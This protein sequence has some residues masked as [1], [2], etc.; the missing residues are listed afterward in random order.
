MRKTLLVGAFAALGACGGDSGS[1]LQGIYS[2]VGWTENTAACTEGASIFPQSDTALYIKNENFLGT[3]F[4]NGMLCTDLAEC[5]ELAADDDTIHLGGFYFEDGN[6]DDGWTG[7]SF[8]GTTDDQGNC[9]GDFFEYSLGGTNDGAVIETRTIPVDGFQ[10][11][12]DGF[13]PYEDAK[14][15]ARDGTCVA[16]E[17]VTVTFE[18]ELP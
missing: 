14:A 13:C 15:A 6:D 1:A 10:E 17:V 2:I 8:F 5:E 4:L 12:A 18:S 7:G 16:L 11:D 9:M 3:K